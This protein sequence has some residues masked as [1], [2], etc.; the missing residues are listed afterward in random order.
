MLPLDI[1]SFTFLNKKIHSA[2]F[3]KQS[4]L[5]EVIVFVL[6]ERLILGP[7]DSFTVRGNLAEY[8]VSILDPLDIHNSEAIIDELDKHVERVSCDPTYSSLYLSGECFLKYE[9]GLFKYTSKLMVYCDP[10]EFE[11]TESL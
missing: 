2:M 1:L 9:Y 7:T 3:T 10:H 8:V 6:G 5:H 11:P 4:H